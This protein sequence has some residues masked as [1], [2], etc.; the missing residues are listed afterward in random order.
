MSEARRRQ[1]PNKRL[2]SSAS[3]LPAHVVPKAFLA[4]SPSYKHTY[5]SMCSRQNRKREKVCVTW[6]RDSS[7]NLKGS[8]RPEWEAGTREGEDKMKAMDDGGG[9]VCTALQDV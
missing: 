3:Q 4:A 5:S 1:R 6:Q 8:S 7:G 9:G 2:R